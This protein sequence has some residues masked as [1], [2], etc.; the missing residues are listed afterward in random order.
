MPGH[1][2]SPW[3]CQRIRRS[4]FGGFSSQE[5]RDD[6]TWQT[7]K[8]PWSHRVIPHQKGLSIILETLSQLVGKRELFHDET[9]ERFRISLPEKGRW[10]S[11]IGI[12]QYNSP[13]QMVRLEISPKGSGQIPGQR[14]SQDHHRSFRGQS[15]SRWH[16]CQTISGWGRSPRSIH[17]SVKTT[18]RLNLHQIGFKRLRSHQICWDIEDSPE[19]DKRRCWAYWAFAEG[20]S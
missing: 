14:G 7:W 19:G 8:Q 18:H 20:G 12:C 17:I 5:N 6:I 16:S 4:H 3:N 2:P 1:Q 9:F 15:F 10:R 13:F 11:K